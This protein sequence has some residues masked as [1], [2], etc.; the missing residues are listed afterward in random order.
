MQVEMNILTEQ[1][2]W[3]LVHP[4]TTSIHVGFHWVFSFKYQLADSIER[5]KVRFVAKGYTQTY[6]VDYF[7]T[8]S[9][10]AGLNSVWILLQFLL[11]LTCLWSSLIWK[12]PFYKLTCKRSMW[13]NL[14]GLLLK[15]DRLSVK[16]NKAIY[17]L[18]QS[19]RAWFVKSDAVVVWLQT[20]SWSFCFC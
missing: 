1:F 6:V 11:I 19:S 18:N 8:F 16:L 13:S 10:I 14:Q 20:N 4:P 3:A 15:G 2:T 12:L 7:D 5:F 17:N 9:L